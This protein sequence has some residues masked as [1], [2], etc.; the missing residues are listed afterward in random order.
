MRMTPDLRRHLTALLLVVTMAVGL[1][2]V[3]A[4]PGHAA[5]SPSIP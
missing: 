5:S 4:T 1:V 2:V 3:A